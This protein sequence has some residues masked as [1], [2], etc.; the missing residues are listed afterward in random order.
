VDK[1]L[2]DCKYDEAITIC[3]KQIDKKGPTP[4]GFY[5]RIF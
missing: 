4:Q 3:S 5:M 1:N 2:E